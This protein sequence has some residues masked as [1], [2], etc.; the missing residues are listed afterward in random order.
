MPPRPGCHR[1]PAGASRPRRWTVPPPGPGELHDLPL[2]AFGVVLHRSGWRVVYLGADTPLADLGRTVEEVRPDAVVLAAVDA[3]RFQQAVTDLVP[4]SRH[5]LLR[6]AGAA[7]TPAVADAI[8]ATVL[9]GDPVTEA[10]R[11]AP[12]GRS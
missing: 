11:L 9:S 3:E 7:A 10:Q 6:L 12:A 5:D 1:R 8:G 2:L 4:L